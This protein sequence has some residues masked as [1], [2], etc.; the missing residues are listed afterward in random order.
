MSRLRYKTQGQRLIMRHLRDEALEL[1]QDKD[2]RIR[3]AVLCMALHD[4]RWMIWVE[5]NLPRR[6]DEC[7]NPQAMM[8]I[9]ARARAVALKPYSYFHNRFIGWLIF[10]HDW[11]F[12]DRGTLSPG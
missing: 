12:T 8:L 5:R 9:E 4:P 11:A 2:R 3:N 6:F 1:R 10:R 7:L